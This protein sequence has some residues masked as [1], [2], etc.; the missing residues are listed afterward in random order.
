MKSRNSKRRIAVVTGSRAEY[1][2]MYWIIRGIHGDADLNLRLIVT[3]MHLSPEFGLTYREIES[4]GFP[5]YEKV[6]MLLSSDTEVGVSQSIGLG[7]IGFSNSLARLKPDIMLIL[8]DR[9]EILAAAVAAH[10]ARIPLAHIHGGEVTEG[11]ADEAVRHSI[12]KMSHIHFPATEVYARRIRQMGEDPERIFNFGS[13]AVDNILRMDLPGREELSRDLGVELGERVAVIT[14]HPVSLE[15]HTFEKQMKNILKALETK[16]MTLVFTYAN[17]DAGGRVIN[18]MIQDFMKT[19]PDAYS[20][21]SLG[22][23]RY[24]G[25]L[26]IADLMVGNSSS[27]I[28]EAPSFGLPVVNIGDRQRGR[29]RAGNVIDCGTDPEEISRALGRALNKEF[30]DSLKDL[31]SPYGT[32]N[33]SN[34]II[35]VL[36]EINLGDELIKKDF[37]DAQAGD[38]ENFGGTP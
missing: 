27:G 13:P 7:I 31:I 3:G 32:G 2:L 36:K 26:S 10:I 14:Y 20:F 25:L 6:E 22:R 28:I 11:S 23:R 34:R 12:T 30:R 24:L 33:T 5:V 37:K 19:R 4:D 29:V 8:G 35:Q 17:A 9:F 21:T 18:R 1:G 38:F 16:D 15:E